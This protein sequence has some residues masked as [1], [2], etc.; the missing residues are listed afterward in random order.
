MI[1]VLIALIAGLMDKLVVAVAL[2]AVAVAGSLV[3]E[4]NLLGHLGSDR[5]VN[6][7]RSQVAMIL[8]QNAMTV[9]VAFLAGLLARAVWRVF[10]RRR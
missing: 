5:P 3:V 6:L 10:T 2:F 7:Y 1:I 8:A 9:F 4:S